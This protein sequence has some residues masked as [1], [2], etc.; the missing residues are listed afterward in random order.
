MS[1]GSRLRQ[2]R[3]GS[4]M[5]QE[6][7]AE[8]LGVTR[9]ALSSY[10]RDRTRPDIEM[11]A[12]LCALYGTDLEGLLYGQERSLRAARRVKTAAAVLFVLLPVLTLCSSL[13][14]WSAGHFFPL[15]EGQLPQ[16][17]MPLLVSHMRLTDA[18]GIV[19]RVILILSPA[20][21]LLL[22][23]LLTVGKCVIPLK[24]KLA[25]AAA[26]AAGMLCASLPFAALDPVREAGDYT[27]VPLVVTVRLLLFLAADLAIEALQKRKKRPPC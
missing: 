1:I 25:Y 7:A 23:L 12:R 6:Q 11:L 22:L 4:G 9:Q 15:P 24:Q 21:F 3:L 10:E 2:L 26:L 13:L 14:L 16:E 20:G 18:W 17:E 8:K 5:T 19:D 27:L